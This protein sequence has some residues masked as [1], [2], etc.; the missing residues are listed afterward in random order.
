MINIY[1]YKI[2]N[3]KDFNLLNQIQREIYKRKYPEV[4]LHFVEGE[5]WCI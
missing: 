5:G 1:K 3:Q 4:D 2:K